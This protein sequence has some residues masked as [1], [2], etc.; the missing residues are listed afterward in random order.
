[1]IDC[2]LFFNELD[3]L[4]I[5]LNSLAPYVDRFVLC[6]STMTHSG[7]SKPLYFQENMGRFSDFSITHLVCD[8]EMTPTAIGNKDSWRRENFQREFLMYGIQDVGPETMILISD[9]DEIPN[10]ADYDGK[11]EGVFRQAMYYYY[12][13]VFIGKTNWKGTSVIRKKNIE[14]LN[15]LRDLRNRT[16][17]VLRQGGWHFSTLGTPEQIIHKIESFAH[18]ELDT[19]GRKSKIAENV[20]AM[21]DPYNRGNGKFI[22]RMPT[23]PKWLLENKDKYLHMFYQ[24]VI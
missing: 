9:V 24:E 3:L 11:S 12:L 2:F 8:G 22:V 16:P 10:L 13:N 21:I 1:M 20:E 18:T 15:K 6:E 5:R 14:T 23:G 19:L 4:E 7:K 17:S